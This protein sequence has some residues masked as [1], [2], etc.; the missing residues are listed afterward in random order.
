VCYSVTQT[1]ALDSILLMGEEEGRGVVD[2]DDNDLKKRSSTAQ[3]VRRST[4]H[5]WVKIL[6]RKCTCLL[7]SYVC[8]YSNK[9]SHVFYVFFLGHPPPEASLFGAGAKRRKVYEGNGRKP[10]SMEASRPL[11]LFSLFLCFA[12]QRCDGAVLL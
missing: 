9:L 7:L 5:T 4:D 11:P 2:N 12:L 1:P 10:A 8:E 6:V 3:R